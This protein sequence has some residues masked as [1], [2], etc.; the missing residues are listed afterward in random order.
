MLQSKNLNVFILAVI[1][2]SI[3]FFEFVRDNINEINIILGKS[4]YFLVLFTFLFVLLGAFIINSLSKKID[5]AESLLISVISFWIL[6]KHNLINQFIK[7]NLGGNILDESFSSEFALLIII[8]LIVL[9]YI[10]F[11]ESLFFKRFCFIFFY[12]S[13]FYIFSQIIFLKIFTV[14]KKLKIKMKLFFWIK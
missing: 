7:R 4:F 10:F 6:F 14:E 13:F 9:T 5:L 12:L 1:I 11:K 2:F 8:I 3:P